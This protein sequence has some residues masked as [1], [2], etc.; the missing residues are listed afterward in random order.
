MKKSKNFF[1]MVSS[2]LMISL[3]CGGGYYGYQFY[4]K[5]V[6]EKE[7]LKQV[8]ARLNADSRIAEAIV[9]EFT[10]N[11]VTQQ[12]TTT[13]K[14]LE[15]DSAGN[16]MPPRYFTFSKNIIQFQSLVVRFEDN[17]VQTGD[18]LRGK[19]IYLFWKAFVLDGAKTQEYVITPVNEVPAGYQLGSVKD[20]F[21]EEIWQEFWNYALRSDKAVTKGIKNAQIEAPGMK[22]VPG[23]LYTL[24][25]EHDGG[26]RIDASAIPA[27]F[28]GEKVL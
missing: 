19:S 8:V 20:P 26:I 5:H 23:M 14:F 9:T 25:I 1:G 6:M 16:P 13:I 15:Y 2:A 4:E 7:I 21:E 27:V 24:K 3:V 28:K 18:A 10:V 17:L 12:A 11:P 22:F